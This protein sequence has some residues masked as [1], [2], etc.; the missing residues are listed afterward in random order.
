[1]TVSQVRGDWLGRSIHGRWT[2]RLCL[3]GTEQ[4]CVF[5]AESQEAP[6]QMAT[7]K[8]IAS[9]SAM[10]RLPAW[11]AAANLS[12]PHLVPIL[13]S[14]RCEMDGQPFVYVAMEY[15]D[16]VLA[17]I[18]P[19]RA[20]TAAE[21]GEM[22]KPVLSALTYLHARGMVHGRLKPANVLVVVDTVKL[23]SDGLMPAGKPTGTVFPADIH[24]APELRAGSVYPAADVWALG[25][26]LVEALTQRVPAWDGAAGSEPEV[27]GTLPQPFQG[28]ARLCLQT[29]PA[30]RSTLHDIRLRLDGVPMAKRPMP[31]ATA[32]VPA[33]GP[34]KMRGLAWVAAA[35]AVLLAI[36]MMVIRSRKVEP[37]FPADQKITMK[38]T[39]PGEKPAAAQSGP[40][41]PSPSTGLS[42]GREPPEQPDQAE[43]PER[44]ESPEH[45]ASGGAQGTSDTGSVLRRVMPE[46]LPEA[47]R[48][49]HGEFHV[50][51]RLTVGADGGVREAG[52]E[53]EGPSRYFA[54]QAL[55][56]AKK[57]RFRP[58]L[59]NGEATVSDWLLDFHFTQGG[60]EV[61]PVRTSP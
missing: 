20:L 26:T 34:S 3:G 16:E 12:H 52:Y 17:E 44:A 4:S 60:A 10:D 41:K 25:V 33:P 8:L 38:E 37:G 13:D 22:L 46:I 40:Q 58:A 57:W 61:N 6:G 39:T 1:M 54:K 30:K 18:L 49:V 21:A 24:T 31:V 53:D 19:E 43:Q 14:G 42:A 11:E 35:V 48:S 27:P 45:E 59:V 9:V 28:I 56:A 50:K 5:L 51:V 36:G 2:L 29:D 55:E 23:S 15:A 32:A 47:Q 7:L